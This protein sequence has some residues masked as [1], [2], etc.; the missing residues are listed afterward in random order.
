MKFF[1]ARPFCS[2]TAQTELLFWKIQDFFFQWQLL[3]WTPSA[4]L[5]LQRNTWDSP[6][7]RCASWL[8]QVF[9][10]KMEMFAT[11]GATQRGAQDA[12]C[13]KLK[14]SS[15]LRRKTGSTPQ[16]WLSSRAHGLTSPP[17]KASGAGEATSAAATDT[18]KLGICATTGGS[19]FR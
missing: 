1:R 9:V 2:S 17:A 8:A 15:V 14:L 12:P 13:P 6:R 19:G 10:Y 3:H 7:P 4:E 11:K 16:L 5:A 18:S